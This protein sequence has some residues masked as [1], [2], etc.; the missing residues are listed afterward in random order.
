MRRKL[1]RV[2]V[3]L[4]LAAAFA[5]SA[6][7]HPAT[8]IVFDGERRVLYFS[9]LETVWKVDAAGRLSTF[10]AGDGGRHTHELGIDRDGNL[11]GGDISYRGGRWF[12]A[13]WRMSPA[14]EFTYLL[15]LTEVAPGW[16]VQRDAAGNVYSVEQDNNRRRETRL[17]RRTPEGRVELVAGG[18]YGQADGRGAAAR[19]ESVAGLSVLPDGTVYLTDGQSLRRVTPDGT[20]TT[21]ARDLGASDPATRLDADAAFGGIYGLAA[22][23]RGGAFVA[24]HRNRR[25]LRVTEA[26]RAT[27]VLRAESPWAP[28]GIAVG[29]DGA[30]YVLEVGLVQAAGDNASRV[31][32]LAPDGSVQTL[33]TV[34]AQGRTGGGQPATPAQAITS[35]EQPAPAG[36][37]ARFY[38]PLVLVGLC[39]VPLAIHFAR[40]RRS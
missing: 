4:S 29:D 21:A 27:T 8:G 5:A 26:G 1:S 9:D 17:L 13:F 10:R 19:F 6:R 25:V 39:L 33:A 12:S 7:A 16:G 11:Y 40:R 38:L 35:H 34:G 18:A 2:V 30:V 32:R 20:V 3:A 22:D 28:T 31:R 37:G 36:R 14:G 23:G 24:D 15:P